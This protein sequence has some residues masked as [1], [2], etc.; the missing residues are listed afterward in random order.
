[1]MEGDRWKALSP[2]LDDLLELNGRAR[3]QRL[4][5]IQATDPGL[6]A[7]LSRLMDLEEERPD[8]MSQPVVS[9]DVGMQAG[10][11]IGPYKLVSPLGEGG[12]G[13][14]WLAVRADGLY[15][16]R[17]AIKLLRPGLGDMGLHA[18]FSRERQILARLGH[19]HI[20]RLLDAGIS[21]EGQPYLALDYVRGEPI[22]DYAQKLNLDVRTRLQLF[23][24]VCAAV[25]HAHAN[26]VV[27]RDLKPSNILVT[28]AGEVCL[29]DFGIA[30]LLDQDQSPSGEITRTGAR[31]F[32]LHYAA[33]E[34]LRGEVITTMTDVYAL[35]VVLYELLTDCKPYEL[36]RAT[37]AAWEEAILEDE[38]G[39]PS[40]VAMRRAKETESVAERRRARALTGDL[41]N[42]I[43]KT[44]SKQ[45]EQRY[46][47]VEALAQDIRRHLDGQPVQARAQS[48]GYRARKYLRRHAV[49][50]GLGVGVTTVLAV[51]LAI[52]SWQA[53][54]AMKE[55]S[56]AQAMQDFVIA[57]FE[58]SGNASST[59]GVDVRALLDA[60]VARADT[61][62]AKQPQARAELLGLI[63]RL[64]SGLGDDAEALALLDRQAELLQPLGAQAPRSLLLDA[65]ALRGYS[66]RMLGRE[67]ECLPALQPMLPTAQAAESAAPL[68]V[69]EF[70]SQLGRCHAALGATPVARD[71]FNR[72]LRLRRANGEAGALVAESE[73]DLAQLTPADQRL[74]ALRKALS[75]L[76]SSGGEQNALGVEI[77]NHLGETYEEL[78]N[79]LEA[80]AAYRQ[81]LDI[82]LARFG[83]N[84]PRTS[85]AQ[86]E[87]SSVLLGAGKLTEAERLLGLAQ[88][89]LLAKWGPDSPQLADKEGMRGMVALERD[90]PAESERLLT[91]SVR[92]W[93][94]RNQID[95][96]AAD[97]CHLAQAQN[98]LGRD[99]QAKVNRRECLDL[100]R[101][102][103]H[104]DPRSA[105][106]ALVHATHAALDRHDLVEA[107]SWMAQLPVPQPDTPAVKLVLA[108]I[109]QVEGDATAASQLEN[110]VAALPTDRSSRRLRWQAQAMLAAQACLDGRMDEGLRLRATTLAEVEKTEPEHARQR[111][112]LAFLSSPCTPGLAVGTPKPTGPQFP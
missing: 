72:A 50:L 110:L 109:A 46:A 88:D 60:G 102:N 68:A 53:S 12:M 73:T 70:L 51:A 33:P 55:A 92:I 64:R 82:A 14:V 96:H 95:E 87:L 36:E 49:G 22:T 17:V 76:R 45:P 101:G 8:F 34:Q 58:N 54:R 52:V 42:I 7:D 11:E 16:R 27:H 9:G 83:A 23:L 25:S 77:W 6:A 99:E 104:P 5:M 43:L 89:S 80:E 2:L 62:L 112:R 105:V 93:R 4:A 40:L 32:T 94:S 61:E 57:L 26:L 35:G 28:S 47:S 15:E 108:R 75:Q 48:L 90:E 38:P 67:R 13:Q 86:Q 91:D 39:R 111:R 10:D 74:G 63:A 84:H 78:H 81:S 29:L 24:Q 41:D 59:R 44:L 79:A 30:K 71:L 18:R 103:A 21:N 66:L 69:A 20:A 97:L 1:M 106:A 100:L 19:A 56:R 31:A 98:E 85:A 3:Q 65:S 107:R 37:D